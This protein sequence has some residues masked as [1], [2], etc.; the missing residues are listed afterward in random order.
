MNKI[1]LAI[2][3]DELMLAFYQSILAEFGTV[4][5]ALNL[6]E[7][8]RQIDGVDLILLDFYLE[9]DQG[10]FQQIVP[11]L[12]KAA[13]VLLCSGIQDERVSGIGSALGVA[14]YWNKRAGHDKLLALVKTVLDKE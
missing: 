5:T 1:I 10:L 3:D 12:K 14:G 13:P 2:D 8:R 9:D 4:R 11:E 7:A 6:A